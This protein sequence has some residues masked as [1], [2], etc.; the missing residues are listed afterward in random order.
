M[1]DFS[2][3]RS[4]R[5]HG[6]WP[7]AAAA[8]GSPLQIVLESVE[9]GLSAGPLWRGLGVLPPREPLPVFVIAKLLR[10]INEESRQKE[11]RKET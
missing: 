6:C 11:G 4:C 7:F 2:R 10:G 5:K 8:G 3:L 1:S 9:S